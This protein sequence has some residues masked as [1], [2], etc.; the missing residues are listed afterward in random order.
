MLV[1][2]VVQNGGKQLMFRWEMLLNALLFRDELE[3]I[4]G[5]K[6]QKIT[7][8]DLTDIHV[9][10]SR[11]PEATNGELDRSLQTSLPVHVMPSRTRVLVK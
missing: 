8:G 10:F 9:K 3:F 4:Y 1:I 5:T 2:C 7:E 11:C 6:G